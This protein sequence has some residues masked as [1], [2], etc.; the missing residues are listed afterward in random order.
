MENLELG[1][2]AASLSI[3]SG[4]KSVASSA[5][6]CVLNGPDRNIER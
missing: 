5:I 4:T 2:H 6:S 1:H 3:A